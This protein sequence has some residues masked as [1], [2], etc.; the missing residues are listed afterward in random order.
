M[1]ELPGMPSLGE[2]WLHSYIAKAGTA[3]VLRG[4]VGRGAKWWHWLFEGIGQLSEGRLDLLQQRMARQ[5]QELGTAFRLPGEERERP[6]PVS[7]MPLLI[8]EDDWA[9]IA[10]AMRCKR[11]RAAD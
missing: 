1:A 2:G 8:G 6:W 4:D 7:A 9:I 10:A 3:D 5:V 11:G